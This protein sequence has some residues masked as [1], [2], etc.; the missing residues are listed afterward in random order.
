MRR[1]PSNGGAYMAS[2]AWDLLRER[3]TAGD[4][5]ARLIRE[6]PVIRGFAD[7]PDLEMARQDFRK[8]ILS[9]DED[10]FASFRAAFIFSF[11]PR[12][13]LVGL[14]DGMD[15]AAQQARYAAYISQN[16]IEAKRFRNFSWLRAD[17]DGI[18]T[19]R[20]D[21]VVFSP[22]E[23]A[24]GDA[25][26][27]LFNRAAPWIQQAVEGAPSDESARALADIA[28]EFGALVNAS[29]PS[30]RMLPHARDMYAQTLEWVART[31]EALHQYAEA[32]RWYLEARRAYAAMGAQTEGEAVASRLRKMN[33]TAEGD[34]DL[35]VADALR[36]LTPD[37]AGAKR[38]LTGSLEHAGAIV[39]LL[40][41]T[42][43]A[44]D[45]FAAEQLADRAVDALVSAGYVDPGLDE[46]DSAFARWVAAVPAELTGNAVFA[47][48]ATVAKL[49]AAVLQARSDV[50]LR[51]PAPAAVP[52]ARI[53]GDSDRAFA[54]MQRF[55]ALISRLGAEVDAAPLR[56]DRAWAEMGA[57]PVEDEA[58]FEARLAEAA[59]GTRTA[60]D[61]LN[62]LARALAAISQQKNERIGRGESLDPLLLEA[63]QHQAVARRL[64]NAR[65]V[66]S[67]AM[68]R[69]D[70]LVMLKRPADALPILSAAQ[71]D[72]F[73]V[74]GGDRPAAA[75]APERAILVDLL[76]YIAVTYSMLGEDALASKTSGEAIDE[77]ELDRYRISSPYL[78]SSFFGTRA[79][80][81]AV[82]VWSA[83][84]TNDREAML[85]RME[86][87]KARSLALLRNPAPG[88]S[89]DRLELERQF[90]AI[91]SEIDADP[92][93][94]DALERRRRVWDLL[95]IARRA[96]RSSQLPRFSLAALHA[97]LDADEAIVYYYWL[98]QNTL[99]VTALDTA[100]VVV[101]RVTLAGDERAAL[102]TLVEALR[103]LQ[104]YNASIDAAVRRF[105]GSFLPASIRA[106]IARKRRLI[107]SP[108]RILH[109][110]PFHALA[111]EDGLLI[112]QFAVSYAPNVSALLLPAFPEPARSVLLIATSDYEIDARGRPLRADGATPQRLPSL[113]GLEQEIEAIAGAYTAAGC[114]T[115]RLL[116]E[117]A[118]KQELHALDDS[119]A[120]ESFGYVHVAT[121][122][123]SAA[124]DEPMESQV[125]LRDAILNGLEISQLQMNA[126]IVV[127]GV[128][129]SGQRA[130][131]ARWMDELGGD[132]LFGLQA[133]F[134][135][136]GARSI[137]GSLWVA[138][139]SA[140]TA[141]L[142]STHRALAQGAL[143]EVALQSAIIEYLA[144]ST[145][146]TRH[147]YYW[148]P[149]F[150]SVMGRRARRKEN[151]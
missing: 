146:M 111:W 35:A 49:Y 63:E 70:M 21:P 91:S 82:G 18:R 102:E 19:L 12:L 90:R 108:H 36:A 50:A 150:I 76:S 7:E 10:A 118:T 60:F 132:D 17:L 123:S 88:P 138:N 115:E 84:K 39:A 28:G 38:P 37:P 53:R 85:E 122:G 58:T 11:A 96:A 95:A 116:N 27:A 8:Y 30:N 89:L 13:R 41:Q 109:Q 9:L 126:D 14:T 40:Q 20:V 130:I 145:A 97:L 61:D 22:D 83:F 131:A 104:R 25:V 112:E 98:S 52:V 68:L 105:S 139:G 47:E 142:T 124:S 81:Y 151:P 55:F 93:N 77:V 4:A 31:H 135:T 33:A 121:H 114:T 15:A 136:A 51:K 54:Q 134:A 46:S 75:A 100:N 67:F 141:V 34:V 65:Y 71:D 86:L 6:W 117:H 148:A 66:A 56:L 74:A 2:N 125:Y 26:T 140:A 62:D 72:L 16:D 42:L 110:F 80:I 113:P 24:L 73:P 101:E 32:Q 1:G 143:P 94:A 48:L 119:R 87:S 79:K 107:V 137:L 29:G 69:A 129:F 147:A 64:G 128:C 23:F 44:S 144:N 3:L 45:V 59:K 120:L 92:G 133:A 43:N 127:L 149:F 106:L 57:N 103:T 99:L 5:R 78:Q